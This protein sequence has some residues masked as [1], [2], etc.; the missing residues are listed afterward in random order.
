ML[1]LHKVTIHGP[2]AHIVDLQA[3]VFAST[4]IE[5]VPGQGQ[6]H[7]LFDL[8]PLS[9]SGATPGAEGFIAGIVQLIVLIELLLGLL[10]TVLLLRLVFELVLFFVVIDVL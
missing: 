9:G 6:L 10:V 1:L 4:D 7:L 5:S 8:D 3:Q 2:V